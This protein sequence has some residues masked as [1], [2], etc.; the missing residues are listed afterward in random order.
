MKLGEAIRDLRKERGI[1]AKDFAEMCGLSKTAL[2]NIE[3][4]RSFPTKPTLKIICEK[5]DVSTAV[6]MVHCIT[7]EDVP[8]EKRE[9]FR[10]LIEPIKKF[11]CEK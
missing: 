6:L 5:L 7:E 1:K 3:K 2:C 10:V 11:L 4:D 8:E 9:A